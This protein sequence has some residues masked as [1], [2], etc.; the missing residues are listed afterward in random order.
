MTKDPEYGNEGQIWQR[1]TSME[2]LRLT[3]GFSL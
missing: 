3:I 1:K 2:Y